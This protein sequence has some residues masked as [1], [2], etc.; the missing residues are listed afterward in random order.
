MKNISFKTYRLIDLLILTGLL[1]IFEMLTSIAPSWFSEKYYISLFFS[2]SLIVLMRWNA[3]AIITILAG[4]VVFCFQNQ[5][6]LQNYVIYIVGN[7]FILCNLLWFIKG[8][9]IFKKNHIVLFYV[10]S[11]YLFVEIG[12]SLVALFF[13]APF[14]ST[15]IGFLGTDLLNVLLTLLIVFIVRRQDGL[16]EDQIIYLKRI[17]EKN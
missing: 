14:F 6:G 17:S 9:K 16:F 2:L 8:K 7:L 13:D 3:W 1:V 10:I 12:R 11:G 15:L 4:T 5:G